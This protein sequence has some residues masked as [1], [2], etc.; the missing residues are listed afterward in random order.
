MEIL[1]GEPVMCM[2]KTNKGILKWSIDPIPT[3]DALYLEG[4]Y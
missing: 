4:V 3:K 1:Y 2:V